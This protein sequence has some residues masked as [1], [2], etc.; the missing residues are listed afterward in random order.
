MEGRDSSELNVATSATGPV[1]AILLSLLDMGR[2]ILK[3]SGAARYRG[4]KMA[5]TESCGARAGNQ[6]TRW[7]K[8]ALAALPVYLYLYRLFSCQSHSMGREYM[9]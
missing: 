7:G 6:K 9:I 8:G 1:E 5:A 3:C 2:P 4:T